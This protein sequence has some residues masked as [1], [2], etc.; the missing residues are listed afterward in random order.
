MLI[1][2]PE[3]AALKYVDRKYYTYYLVSAPAYGTKHVGTESTYYSP[4]K[5]DQ[6]CRCRRLFMAESLGGCVGRRGVR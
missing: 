6:L 4:C 5:K 3:V 2:K 1:E